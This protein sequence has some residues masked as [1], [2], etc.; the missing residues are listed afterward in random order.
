MLVLDFSRVHQTP[1][2]HVSPT[3]L[4]HLLCL[5][6]GRGEAQGKGLLPCSPRQVV[7]GWAGGVIVCCQFSLKLHLWSQHLTLYDVVAWLRGAFWLPSWKLR[8]RLSWASAKIES[9]IAVFK[10]LPNPCLNPKGDSS[11]CCCPHFIGEET[12]AQ[13]GLSMCLRS[14]SFAG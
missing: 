8:H 6:S 9:K 4:G 7:W 5:L 2:R 1:M 11:S 10:I 12:E 3:L 14:P 13:R